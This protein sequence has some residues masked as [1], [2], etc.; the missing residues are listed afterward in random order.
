M[1]SFHCPSGPRSNWETQGHRRVLLWRWPYFQFQA[2]MNSLEKS[3]RTDLGIASAHALN[4][5][6]RMTCDEIAAYCDCSR[7]R[8][9][10]IERRAMAKVRKAFRRQG[11]EE[12]LR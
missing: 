1:V 7:S 12:D 6:R 3:Q 4:S 8:I 9:Q 11:V 10:Q 5:R 2:S